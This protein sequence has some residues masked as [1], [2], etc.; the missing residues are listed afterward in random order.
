MPN[1]PRFTPGANQDNTLRASTRD[2]QATTYASSVA[3]KTSKDETFVNF[4]SVTGALTLTAVITN[5]YIGD[6]LAI[7]F[8]CDATSRTVTFST[9]FVVSASTLV[10]GISKYGSIQFRFNGTVW[11]ETGRAVTA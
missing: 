6:Q 9:N 7:T 2:Y 10:L 3:I 1:T 11:V 8:T 5:A 4:A